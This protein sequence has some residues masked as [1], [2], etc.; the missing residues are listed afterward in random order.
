MKREY[1]WCGEWEAV[2]TFLRHYFVIRPELLA[3]IT[4]C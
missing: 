1:D 2:V 3:T 4:D